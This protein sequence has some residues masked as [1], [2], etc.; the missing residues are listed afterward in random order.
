VMPKGSE[1]MAGAVIA[2]EGAAVAVVTVEAGEAE[3]MVA[4]TEGM[5][6]RA[7]AGWVVV[8]GVTD[9]AAVGMQ[10]ARL[11]PES[12]L[13]HA[14]VFNEEAMPGRGD[15][16]LC[17][18]ASRSGRG[19]HR[20]A[21][22]GEHAA[23]V[24]HRLMR[25]G[26]DRGRSVTPGSGVRDMPSVTAGRRSH[27]EHLLVEPATASSVHTPLPSGN[28]LVAVRAANDAFCGDGV[29]DVR[30]VLRARRNSMAYEAG[31]VVER[32]LPELLCD[33]RHARTAVEGA[34]QTAGKGRQR[35]GLAT[36][37]H[38]LHA[39]GNAALPSVSGPCDAVGCILEWAGRVDKVGV[40]ASVGAEATE[41]AL[42]GDG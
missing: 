27:G 30:S 6:S 23:F 26:G 3:V 17:E 24:L 15:A 33:G 11:G 32:R 35:S 2:D 39:G 25:G 16:P 9:V 4:A 37:A 36:R 42:R 18:A 20:E 28:G 41:A 22:R 29:D 14:E 13:P 40:A 31:S 5:S 7:A 21:G 12:A 38:V 1:A 10:G 8:E 19:G 34:S